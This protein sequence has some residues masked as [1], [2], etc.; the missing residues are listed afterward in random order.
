MCI[1]FGVYCLSR[2]GNE[3]CLGKT[4]SEGKQF[5][6]AFYCFDS[7]CLNTVMAAILEI[8]FERQKSMKVPP[9]FPS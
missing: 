2:Y 5:Y 4:L 8:K 6:D 3:N 7:F 1:S 9:S